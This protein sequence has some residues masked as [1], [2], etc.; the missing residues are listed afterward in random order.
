MLLGTVALAGDG[1]S[2]TGAAP[3]ARGGTPCDELLRKELSI[4]VAKLVRT[5]PPPKRA[6][7]VLWMR[8]FTSSEMART[9]GMSRAMARYH[10]STGLARLLR[11]LM[12]NKGKWRIILTDFGPTDCIPMSA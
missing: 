1:T 3:R 2:P 9:L 5:L 8:D 6:A 12:D 10:V 4:E 7:I 11:E